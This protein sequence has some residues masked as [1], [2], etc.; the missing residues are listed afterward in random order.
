MR[1]ATAA[2]IAACA[3]VGL[4]YWS[5]HPQAGHLW[6]VDDNQRAH[7]VQIDAKG[8]RARRVEPR[9]HQWAPLQ[10]GPWQAFDPANWAAAMAP[11][12]N[13]RNAA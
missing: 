1:K 4:S 3:A 8:Q 13:E 5:G 10:A 6:A 2:R 9:S 7:A 11:S 12:D